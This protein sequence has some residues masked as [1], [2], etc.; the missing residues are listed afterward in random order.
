MRKTFVFIFILHY[1]VHNENNKV[2]INVFYYFKI[3][4]IRGFTPPILNEKLHTMSARL[5]DTVVIPC[6]AYANPPPSNR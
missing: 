5:E 1:F 6:V 2:I 4:E 3:T